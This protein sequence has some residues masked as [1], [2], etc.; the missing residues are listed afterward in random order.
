[1]IKGT[2]RFT[3]HAPGAGLNDNN[4]GSW[5]RIGCL[6]GGHYLNSYRRRS[7]WVG[8]A[9][10]I[11]G[12]TYSAGLVT[13]YP[14]AVLH[15]YASEGYHAGTWNILIIPKTRY[16]SPAI[17]CSTVERISLLSFVRQRLSR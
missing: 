9:V 16:N 2:H 10:D 11:R 4:P 12:V 3:I 15:P 5:I 6:A 17:H 14:G 13:G 7:V 8:L 1:M